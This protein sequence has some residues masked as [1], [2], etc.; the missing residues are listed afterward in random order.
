VR[1]TV[2]VELHLADDVIHAIYCRVKSIFVVELF[3]PLASV[4]RV[5]ASPGSPQSWLEAFL[6]ELGRN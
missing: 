1:S 5:I 3:I 2:V 6:E 4:A